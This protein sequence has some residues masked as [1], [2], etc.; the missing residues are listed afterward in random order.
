MVWALNGLQQ[1]WQHGM[2]NREKESQW[3]HAATISTAD[4]YNRQNR[5]ELTRNEDTC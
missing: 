3:W 4:G 5:K 2:S 1:L